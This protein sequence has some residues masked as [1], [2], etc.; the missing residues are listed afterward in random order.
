LVLSFSLRGCMRID[1]YA[2][3]K[4]AKLDGTPSTRPRQHTH[5]AGRL[6]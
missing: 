5:D 3:N 2:A 1:P 4:S 6:N